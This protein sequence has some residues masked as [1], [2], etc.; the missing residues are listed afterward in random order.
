MRRTAL[1]FLMLLAS[2]RPLAHESISE[3][4]AVVAPGPA[5][6]H[7]SGVRFQAVKMAPPPPRA[8]AVPRTMRLDVSGQDLARATS[9]ECARDRLCK[10]I[11]NRPVAFEHDLPAG[12]PGL[13]A[14][15]VVGYEQA[16]GDE[17]TI[18]FRGFKVGTA[19]VH[20]HCL[21]KILEAR[22]EL[23]VNVRQTIGKEGEKPTYKA[24]PFCK[25]SISCDTPFLSI[26]LR[27]DQEGIALEG[28]VKSSG[29]TE[30]FLLGKVMPTKSAGSKTPYKELPA[31][32]KKLK[33][34]VA[35]A[36]DILDTDYAWSDLAQGCDPVPAAETLPQGAG[37]P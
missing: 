25:A 16:P 35:E 21:G 11:I 8:K 17:G 10:A 15:I 31:H 28:T 22:V 7:L 26:G 12:V 20:P 34:A 27:A 14:K 19:L 2:C 1:A 24:Q 32:V 30:N 23:G 6:K 13:N 36:K 18:C 3:P 9:I 4:E 5:C 29:L 37:K 33:D